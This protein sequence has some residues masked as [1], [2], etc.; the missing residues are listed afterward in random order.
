MGEAKEELKATTQ[1][2]GLEELT[3]KYEVLSEEHLELKALVKRMQV[4]LGL[5]GLN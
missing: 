5:E 4:H 2:P 3:R 1:E